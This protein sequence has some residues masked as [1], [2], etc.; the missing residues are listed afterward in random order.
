MNTLHTDYRY[1]KHGIHILVLDT[2]Y[3]FYYANEDNWVF[4]MGVYFPENRGKN[5]R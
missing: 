1:T 4:Y 5:S 3:K 2:C